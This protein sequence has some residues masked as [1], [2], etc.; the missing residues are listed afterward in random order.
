MASIYMHIPFCKKRCNYC[1]FY[2]SI[3]IEYLDNY[4][5]AITK[6]IEIQSDYFGNEEIETIYFGGGTPSIMRTIEVEKLINSLKK[7]FNLSNNPEITIEVN[8]DDCNN[9][10]FKSIKS[11]GFNRISIGVQSFD[12][13]T[14]KL[15]NRRHTAKQV[16]ECIEY[17][18]NAEIQ[19]INI[20]L[21]YGLP[22][23][24]QENWIMTLR[25]LLNYQ[26]NIYLHITSHMKKEQFFINE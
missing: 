23:M 7:N 21:I 18:I 25:R 22:E 10:Y 9:K 11:I 1:D 3:K 14:L 15:M 6:E 12:D 16:Y 13:K 2:S 17:A 8:P 4:L 20:D 26:Y 24:S 5:K 19:N